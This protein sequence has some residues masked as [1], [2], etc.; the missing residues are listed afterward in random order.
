MYGDG[1]ALYDEYDQALA[2]LAD[3]A[4]HPVLVHCARGAFRTGAVIALYRVRA[5]GWG[6]EEVVREMRAYRF[7]ERKERPLLP[8]LKKYLYARKNRI[9]SVDIAPSAR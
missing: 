4:L 6:E 2:V 3:P 7:F 5:Q 9:L 1:I 8:H